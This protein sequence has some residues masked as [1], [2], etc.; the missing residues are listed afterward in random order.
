VIQVIQN[1]PLG[2]RMTDTPTRMACRLRNVR[3]FV[4]AEMLA[5]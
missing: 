1:T 4:A 5:A 3:T 2:S